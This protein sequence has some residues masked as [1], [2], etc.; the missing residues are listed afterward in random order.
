MKRGVAGTSVTA[1]RRASEAGRLRGHRARLLAALRAAQVPL[2]RRQLSALTGIPVNA[3]PGAILALLDAGLVRKSGESVDPQTG[4]RAELLEPTLHAPPE[5][6]FTWPP[7]RHLV[8]SRL[9]LV[10]VARRPT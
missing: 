9:P 10:D 2:S 3:V 4:F 5:R 7:A 8:Q 1:Y 6:Q